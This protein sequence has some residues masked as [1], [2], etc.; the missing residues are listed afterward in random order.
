MASHIDMETND[1][2]ELLT[3]MPIVFIALC[4]GGPLAE[5]LGWRGFAQERLQ[6]TMGPAWA[7]VLVGLAWS[8]W[9]IPITILLPSAYVNLPLVWFL[10]NV[11]ALGLWQAWLYVR[12]NGSVLL[13][14][15][16]HAAGNLVMGALGFPVLNDRV[17]TI[18][19]GLN[20]IVAVYLF[21]ILQKR[22]VSQAT[23]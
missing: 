13:C 11:V 1:P 6:Q 15:L 7:G 14:L 12:S 9:H 4:F 19:V 21:V 10:P 22:S 3:V 20:G 2:I 18:F 16:F 5:E 23:T 17:R 8:F